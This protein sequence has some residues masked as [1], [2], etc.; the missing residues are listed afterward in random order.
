MF[1]IRAS[2]RFCDED[3]LFGIIDDDAVN[4]WKDEILVDGWYVGREDGMR[5]LVASEE[6]V[7]TALRTANLACFIMD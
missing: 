1:C 3:T 4:A 2:L 7:A 5:R 6:A